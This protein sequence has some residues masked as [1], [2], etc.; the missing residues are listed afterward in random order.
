MSWTKDEEE[1]RRDR[2]SDE[3][4]SSFVYSSSFDV[5]LLGRVYASSRPKYRSRRYVSS[6]KSSCWTVV[7]GSV[8]SKETPSFVLRFRLLYPSL[9]SNSLPPLYAGSLPPMNP[10]RPHLLLR[11]SF[12]SSL[13]KSSQ[14]SLA[15]PRSF[16]T[17]LPPSALNQQPRARFS[18]PP[19]AL[20]SLRHLN[21]RSYASFNPNPNPQPSFP[22]L[23]TPSPEAGGKKGEE[24]EKKG[25]GLMGFSLTNSPVL[26][27][28][29][30]TFVGLFLVFGSGIA[31]LAWYKVS[32]SSPSSSS[33]RLKEKESTS[34]S[35]PLMHCPSLSS[36]SPPSPLFFP[37]PVHR[38]PSH[39]Q[40]LRSRIRSSSRSLQRFS[41]SSTSLG[42]IGSERG[43]RG[44]SYRPRRAGF[45]RQDHPRRGAREL[46]LDH[47]VQGT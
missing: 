34:S 28:A 27:A 20:S 35:S 29:L 37:S 17:F 40:S 25:G 1:E 43:R 42:R 2:R 5:D 16:H 45:R 33:N 9:S 26:D 18:S 23:N 31:Y 38:P 8:L 44:R 14:S 6:R 46:L 22:D 36:T 15:F 24:K 13:S 41:S 21:H 32:F 12:L 3:R 19:P 10:L 4:L 7:V 39:V 47:R 30:A 11:P